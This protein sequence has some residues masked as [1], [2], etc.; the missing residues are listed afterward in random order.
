MLFGGSEDLADVW[1]W[2]GAAGSWSM[3]A[4]TSAAPPGR[5]NAAA[6]ADPSRGVVVVYGGS[7]AGGDLDDL[8]E[9][10]GAAGSWSMRSP[11]GAR[12]PPRTRAT[13]VYEPGSRRLV[14]YG[15]YP[16]LDVSELWAW[17]GAAGSWTRLSPNPLP[18]TWP[19]GRSGHAAAFDAA[20]GRLVVF[21]GLG[22]GSPAIMRDAWEW[23]PTP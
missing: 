3:R 9:W 4:V 12:P 8:W 7:Y 22:A 16:A 14:L 19:P 20:R 6:A 18:A 13:L 21:G 23:D 1:E 11:A 5:S 17:D 10:D 15:G 2:D